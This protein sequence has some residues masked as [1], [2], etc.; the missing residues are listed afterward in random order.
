MTAGNLN[1]NQVCRVSI[2][3]YMDFGLIQQEYVN[4]MHWE[5]LPAEFYGMAE[6]STLS[7]IYMDDLIPFLRN[8]YYSD[9][10]IFTQLRLR[11]VTGDGM[12]ELITPIGLAGTRTRDGDR[13]PPYSALV[14]SL[15]TA[16]IGRRYR[17]RNYLGGFAE[18]DQQNG[19]WEADTANLVQGYIDGFATHHPG[20]FFSGVWSLGVLSDPER[21]LPNGTASE[22]TNRPT[23]NGVISLESKPIVYVQRKRKFRSLL[24]IS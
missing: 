6:M 8:C 23:I 19:L 7:E 1:M 18:Q 3:G 20:P 24:D 4:V 14:I 2:E 13:L 9:T 5:Y 16:Y 22:L 17:G 11:Q 21:T 12:L 10:T 15:K